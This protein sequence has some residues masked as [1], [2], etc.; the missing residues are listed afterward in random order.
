MYEE[1]DGFPATT[2]TVAFDMNVGAVPDSVAVETRVVYPLFSAGSL[3]HIL[4]LDAGDQ[5]RGVLTGYKIVTS[6][7]PE[8]D[9]RFFYVS[10]IGIKQHSVSF[11]LKFHK[12][13]DPTIKVNPFLVKSP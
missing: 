11:W 8:D 9:W 4:P 13:K 6:A 10:T 7:G 12:G 3:Y 5:D 1:P 2:P